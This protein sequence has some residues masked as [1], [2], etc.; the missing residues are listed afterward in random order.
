MVFSLFKR[1]RT[2]SDSILSIPCNPGVYR[3]IS[4]MQEILYIGASGNLQKRVSQYFRQASNSDRKS[5]TIKRN[6]RFIEYQIHNDVESAFEAE[7]IEIWTNQPHLNI[8]GNSVHSFS[9]LVVRKN[10]FLHIICLEESDFSK[11]ALDDEFYRINTHIRDLVEK[12]ETI[13]RKLPFCINSSN[14]SCWDYQLRLCSNNCRKIHNDFDNKSSNNINTLIE[15]IKSKESA[16]KPNWSSYITVYSEDLQ[17]EKAG[18]YKA[19]LDA[20]EGLQNYFGGQASLRNIDSFTFNLTNDEKTPISVQ[21]TSHNEGNSI[22][23]K[24]ESIQNSKKFATEILI[25]YYLLKYYRDA[26]SLPNEVQINY[27][28]SEEIQNR[29]HKRIRRFYHRSVNLRVINHKDFCY[30]PDFSTK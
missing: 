5:T 18:K 27:P 6:T 10:P 14:K 29:F 13:R 8:R 12:L 22:V 2:D 20:L 9:Y 7:R 11:I 24:Q 15:N 1:I 23:R 21:I 4:D 26:A 16:L 25:L 28:L 17:F 30:K 3:F 19:A